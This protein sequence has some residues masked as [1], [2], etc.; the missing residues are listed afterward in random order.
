MTAEGTPFLGSTKH[1]L[2][3]FLHMYAVHSLSEVQLPMINI[4][5]V[6]A[7]DPVNE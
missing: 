7:H 2:F 5:Q 6:S 1:L 3:Q 4:Q